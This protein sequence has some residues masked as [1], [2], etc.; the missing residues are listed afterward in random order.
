MDKNHREDDQS[1]TNEGRMY[2]TGE[3]KIC[4]PLSKFWIT[5]PT[6][7]LQ[8]K[9]LRMST[10]FRQR[11]MSCHS[12][13]TLHCKA[14]SW[15]QQT[16]A[17]SKERSEIFWRRLLVLC[18]PCWPW[19]PGHCH[20]ET[21]NKAGAQWPLHQ[22]LHKGNLYANLGWCWVWSMAHYFPIIAQKWIHSQAVHDQMSRVEETTD[23]RST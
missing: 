13:W 12:I 16:V 9:H 3:Y 6:P 5:T 21:A 7:H 22:P 11:W 18:S 14:S 8:N 1:N 2:A 10:F 15:Q 19:P 17:K 20:E 23:V 4:S